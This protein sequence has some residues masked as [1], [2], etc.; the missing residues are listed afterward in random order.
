VAAISGY[1]FGGGA[2]IGG[3]GLSPFFR[4]DPSGDLSGTHQIAK[5]DRQMAPLAG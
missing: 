2:M 5:Q 1:R 3:A 4:I